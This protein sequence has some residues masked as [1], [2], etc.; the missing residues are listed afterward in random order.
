[1][2]GFIFAAAAAG[3]LQ[4]LVNSSLC[5][6]SIL[7][8]SAPAPDGPADPVE[9]RQIF[10]KEVR[11]LGKPPATLGEQQERFAGALAAGLDLYGAVQMAACFLDGAK[12]LMHTLRAAQTTVDRMRVPAFLA[13]DLNQVSAVRRHVGRAVATAAKLLLGARTEYVLLFSRLRSEDP[14]EALRALAGARAPMQGQVRQWGPVPTAYPAGGDIDDADATGDDSAAGDDSDSDDET[15][16]DRNMGG[17]DASWW[18]GGQDEDAEG[19]ALSS[20]EDDA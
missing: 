16:G 20:E 1:M 3:V 17:P 14:L 15:G 9:A 8:Q 12:N 13:G 11:Y 10:V 7:V 2:L 19:E 18:D 4:F 5:P 6:L